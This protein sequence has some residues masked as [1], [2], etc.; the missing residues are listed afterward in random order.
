VILEVGGEGLVLRLLRLDDLLEAIT[1]ANRHE[2]VD[3]G[4]AT[5]R[6]A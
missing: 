1:E 3:W 2:E 5:G 4:P 6:E